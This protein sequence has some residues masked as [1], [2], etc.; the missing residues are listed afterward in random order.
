M[1]RPVGSGCTLAAG[2]GGSPRG[3][4]A[5]GLP[6]AGGGGPRGASWRPG[7]DKRDTCDYNGGKI[8]SA[9]LHSAP[10]AGECGEGCWFLTLASLDT[11]VQ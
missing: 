6:S 5:P 10:P 9:T 2:P 3:V 8:F 11:E 4:A 7:P 1:G